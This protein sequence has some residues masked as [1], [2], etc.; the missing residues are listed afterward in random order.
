VDLSASAPQYSPRRRTR[1]GSI[2]FF[3]LIH[4]A[5]LIAAPAHILHN[6]VASF[7]VWLSALYGLATIL[8]IT[9]GYHRLFS[10]VAFKAHP[11]VKVACLF[12]GAA[13]FQQSALKWSS[14]HR[15]HHQLTDTTEDPYNIQ[16][17]FWYAHMGWILFWKQPVDYANVPDLQKDPMVVFQHRYFQYCALIAGLITP[18]V[19]GWAAG[20]GL[21][22]LLFAVGVRL[23]AVFH[24][25]FFIN[26]FAHTFGTRN[27]DAHSSARD[28][29]ICAILTNGEG[30]HNFHHAFP[31]D[32]RNGI[33]WYHWDPSKW[34]I[35][36]GSLVGL[37]SDL[38]RSSNARI[39]EARERASRD[40]AAT[41]STAVFAR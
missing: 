25:T 23:V 26:S 33:R 9:V 39:L 7:T 41:P 21:E 24:F 22:A 29:W 6:G 40:R 17:G 20:Q 1:W 14:L 36:L 37:T 10:H 12:F 32:Y 5:A 8:A 34:L 28:S 30:Y 4:A 18:L 16:F 15:R 19:I 35:Y 27:Y 3:V 2:A 13:T 38:K 11:I 31:A